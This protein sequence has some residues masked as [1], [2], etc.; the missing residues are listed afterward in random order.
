MNPQKVNVINTLQL[1]ASPVQQKDYNDNVPI[2]Q[3]AGELICQWFDDFF[4]PED[5]DFRELF[6]IQEWQI[7]MEFHNF[8]EERVD[9]LP[10]T[11]E[12]MRYSSVWTEV[13]GKANWALSRLG[14]IDLVVSY[15]D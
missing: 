11:Y 10:D 4:H 1:I 5:S 9:K 8:Y 12:A 15:D 7:L 6:S 3:V 14:W 13:V 2:A